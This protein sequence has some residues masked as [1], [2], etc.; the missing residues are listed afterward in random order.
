[1]IFAEIDTRGR[2][3]LEEGLKTATEAKWYRRLKVIDLSSQGERVP[4]LAQVFDLSQD[5]VRDYIKRYNRGGLAGLRPTY[6]PGRSGK[7]SLSKAELEEVLRRS[8][9]QYEKLDTGAR[10]WNQALMQAYLKLYHQITLSQG[11][12]SG[13]FKRLGI[14]WSRAKKSDL[15]RPALHRQAGAVGPVES[16]G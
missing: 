10:N 8:P 14:S 3:E 7:I 12:I 1:M 4:A 6:G 5:T 15:A 9:S 16:P 13:T 11:A 2:K